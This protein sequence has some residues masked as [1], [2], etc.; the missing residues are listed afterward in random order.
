MDQ[1]KPRT[2]ELP[3]PE[4]VDCRFFEHEEECIL[5]V[6]LSG[7]CSWGSRGWNYGDFLYRRVGLALLTVEPMAVLFDM[8]KLE[9][10]YGD[11]MLRLFQLF[12]DIRPSGE[13]RILTAFVLSDSNRFGM[14]S[15]VG[16]DP[17][18]PHAPFFRN[19]DEA[20]RYL[21]KEYDKI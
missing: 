9:Y 16:F 3:V 11:R 4:E 15:L 5:K 8:E 13:S 14:S 7:R 21:F 20:Y 6:E 19:E 17:D 12:D 2:I 10:E 18:Q 1:F